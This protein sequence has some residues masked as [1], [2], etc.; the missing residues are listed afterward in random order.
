MVWGMARERAWGN[1]GAYVRERVR[2]SGMLITRA[3]A[4][5]KAWGDS[6][7]DGKGE[8]ADEGEGEG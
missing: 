1:V 6:E 3:R 5:V 4:R 8:G 2:V 7:G